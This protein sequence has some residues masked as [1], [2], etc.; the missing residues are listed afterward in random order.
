[1]KPLFVGLP[2][3]GLV[4]SLCVATAEAGVLDIPRN[5]ENTIHVQP[6]GYLYAHPVDYWWHKDPSASGSWDYFTPVKHFDEPVRL[7]KSVRGVL[8]EETS[9]LVPSERVESWKEL[10]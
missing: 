2:I 5:S 4:F 9:V 8:G 6:R 7:S 3:L 1:M 10:P